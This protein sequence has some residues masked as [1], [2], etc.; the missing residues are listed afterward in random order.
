MRCA[1]EEES[2]G[3]HVF[4]ALA[5][6]EKWERWEDW[7][8]CEYCECW[9]ACGA[10]LGNGKDGLAGRTRLKWPLPK[11]GLLRCERRLF[12]LQY[13]SFCNVMGGI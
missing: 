7:E 9:E 6:G 4:F 13:T 5:G 2:S 10:G 11:D 12:T 3:A 1:P 8:K